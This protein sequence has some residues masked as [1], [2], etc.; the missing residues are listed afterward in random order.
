[1]NPL[2]RGACPGIADPML[3]GDGL[4][5]R[6]IPRAPIPLDTFVALC[7]AARTHGNGVVEV[8]QRGSLQI[9][10]LSSQSA[11][12]FARAVTALDLGDPVGP[13][14]LTSP[15][16]GSDADQTDL[17]TLL[18]D[19]QAKFAAGA[20]TGLGPK[21]SVLL[22][23]GGKLHLDE[24]SGD[25]RLRATP[26]GFNLSIGGKAA[27]SVSLGWMRPHHA[28]QA[29]MEVLTRI[30]NRGSHARARDFA[31]DLDIRALRESLVGVLADGPPPASRA[32]AEPLGIHRLRNGQVALGVAL[33]FGYADTLAL[34]RLVLAVRQ[35]GATAI[36]PT[37]GRALLIM[38][39]DAGAAQELATTLTAHGLIVTSDDARRYVVAC[40]GAPAC[41]SAA[42][43]TRQLAPAIA[44]AAKP[45][46]GGATTIHVSGCAKGCAHPGAAALT[47][48]GP[49]RIVV[50]GR[51]SDTPHGT[52]S[53]A[54]L[55]AGLWRLRTQTITSQPREAGTTMLTRFSAKHIVESLGGK[56]L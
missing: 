9:R 24:V 11:I 50:Q 39:L 27:T 45:F 49:D 4:L 20:V 37:P 18:A 33:A 47:L 31:N 32:P 23:G 38:N 41:A 14:I 19:L 5:A 46:L 3:T 54:H 22:D 26:A 2:R 42:L 30:A 17:A 53:P 21:V 7:D 40:A 48:I 55:I 25:L 35:S 29:T 44:E 43:S 56:P 52:I 1:M 15:L 28:V 51:A 8:T 16:F 10:G 6:L 13:P 34:E 36:R 12:E